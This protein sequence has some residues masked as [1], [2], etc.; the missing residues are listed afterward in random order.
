MKH[1]MRSIK[2]V[3]DFDHEEMDEDFRAKGV[4]M[5]ACRAI[6]CQ[7]REMDTTWREQNEHRL[8]FISGTRTHEVMSDNVQHAI[9]F[10]PSTGSAHS[11]KRSCHAPKQTQL[12]S[13]YA[14]LSRKLG[15]GWGLHAAEDIPEGCYIMWYG[16]EFI[17]EDSTIQ[18]YVNLADSSHLKNLAGSLSKPEVINGNS[19]LHTPE[20]LVMAHQAAAMANDPDVDLSAPAAGT[21]KVLHN[22]EYVYLQHTGYLPL[23]QTRLHPDRKDAKLYIRIWLKATRDIKM[24]E[25]IL[26][27]YG[28]NFSGAAHRDLDLI[29]L[30]FSRDV[31]AKETEDR[32]AKG[33][34]V[35]ERESMPTCFLHP[36]LTCLLNDAC[37]VVH[38]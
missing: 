27:S 11:A 18:S 28:K 17:P 16:G 23:G 19:P 31:E 4:D 24:G 35:S 2:Y 29:N 20:A 1:V 10:G 7:H 12:P 38:V 14:Y 32:R 33:L 13:A 37:G 3:E 21:A 5:E 22:A 15:A 26:V 30:K 25:E 34:D 8:P 36:K 6:F 9:Y